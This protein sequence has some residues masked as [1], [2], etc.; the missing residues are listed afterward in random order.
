[1]PVIIRLVSAV[2]FNRAGEKIS[3]KWLP[4]PSP[5]SW[6]RC[7]P[8][9]LARC[10]GCRAPSAGSIPPRTMPATPIAPAARNTAADRADSPRPS[11]PPIRCIVPTALPRCCGRIIFP[12][13]HRADRPFAAEA[14]ALQGVTSNCSK[15]FVNPQRKVKNANQGC[16][17]AECAR[18]RMV[19]H[20]PRQPAADRRTNDR[21]GGDPAGLDFRHAHTAIRV[22]TT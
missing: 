17:T 8:P 12:D 18:D 1:M 15:E 19:C 6:S 13:Q 4:V 3:R 11:P 2:V 5:W 16:S 22:G 14:Q 20:H 9:A 7:R 10:A 21:R